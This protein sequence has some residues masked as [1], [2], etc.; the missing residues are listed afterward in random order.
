MPRSTKND[1]LQYVVNEGDTPVYF[2]W[3]GKTF[4]W[5]PHP[6]HG[7]NEHY[8]HAAVAGKIPPK[9]VRVGNEMVEIGVTADG[10]VGFN[11]HLAP[12]VPVWRH[13]C[14]ADMVEAMREPGN[15][16]H[17]DP[18]RRT[19]KLVFAS[20]M[21]DRY[22]AGALAAQSSATQAHLEE[23]AARERL[24]ALRAEIAAA[25]EVAKAKNLLDVLSPTGE[26]ER[27]P[28]HSAPKR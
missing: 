2:G 13:L 18:Q 10:V 7:K 4:I 11:L 22:E 9:R 5:D 25:E 8:E 1:P 21:L 14:P 17:R 24:A 28:K 3:D 20:Q 15:L 27:R 26:D 23:A 6:K 12:G 16:H 19:E